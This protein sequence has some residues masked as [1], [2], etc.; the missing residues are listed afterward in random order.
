MLTPPFPTQELPNPNTDLNAMSEDNWTIQALVNDL[1]SKPDLRKQV[2]GLWNSHKEPEAA[3]AAPTSPT[4]MRSRVEK[5]EAE[6]KRL[7]AEAERLKAMLESDGGT[8]EVRESVRGGVRGGGRAVECRAVECRKRRGESGRGQSGGEAERE[9]SGERRRRGRGAERERQMRRAEREREREAAREEG[10]GRA[11]G[12]RG[13]GRGS[14]RGR[15]REGRGEGEG[16]AEGAGEGRER[17]QGGL[18]RS[19]RTRVGHAPGSSGGVD[20]RAA[21]RKKVVRKKDPAPEEE[22]EEDTDPAQHVNLE[23]KAATGKFKNELVQFQNLKLDATADIEVSIQ[24][25]GEAIVISDGRQVCSFTLPGFSKGVFRTTP[26]KLFVN[27]TLVTSDRWPNGL[28][29]KQRSKGLRLEM[30]VYG[31]SIKIISIEQENEWN[32]LSPEEQDARER[33]QRD[34]KSFELEDVLRAMREDEHG[35]VHDSSKALVNPYRTAYGKV[36]S[37]SRNK[38][39]PTARARRSSGSLGKAKSPSGQPRT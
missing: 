26:S 6:A 29:E 20:S 36:C 13:R 31:S 16:E 4:Q 8:R 18:R 28:P 35:R 30:L 17:E 3:A 38:T 12:G 15:Q 21:P 39:L 33:A 9:W 14:G 32:R 34:P 25:G 7:K 22:E 10:E 27:P 11:R 19:T 23:G 1:R 37:A 5:L 24:A 2:M